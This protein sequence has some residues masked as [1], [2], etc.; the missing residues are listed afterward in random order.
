MHTVEKC[1]AGHVA[2]SCWYRS[3]HVPCLGRLLYN[4]LIGE[5]G[6]RLAESL[7]RLVAD[8]HHEC[9]GTR[10]QHGFRLQACCHVL[11]VQHNP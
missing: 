6:S 4:T 1:D 7:V 2:C 3:V 11:I 9:I 5:V 10:A 8:V